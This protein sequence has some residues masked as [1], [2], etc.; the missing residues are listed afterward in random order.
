[1]CCRKATEG[2]NPSLSAIFDHHALGQRGSLNATYR[3][4]AEIGQF[5]AAL[6][7]AKRAFTLAAPDSHMRR[8]LPLLAHAFPAL[9]TSL[10][11]AAAEA[12]SPP[13]A[14]QPKPNILWV[15][16]EDNTYNFVGAYGDPLAR[17]PN[18]DLLAAQGIVFDL[19]HSS[20]PVCAPSRHT[21]I[22]G[23]Y[24]TTHGAQHMRSQRPLPPGV[25][26]FPE[27]LRAAGYY[28]TNNTKTDYN[29][30]TPFDHVWNE[31]GRN[32][33][34]RHRAP[35]QP[36]F[37]V[38]NFEHSHES[39]QHKREPLIT[40]PA[41]V[42]L[43]AYLPDTPT[44][45]AD[46]AQYYD[47]VSRAD[48]AI[49][50]VLK[51]LAEDGLADDTIVLYYSDNGGTLPRSK[52]FLWDNGTHVAMIA[53]FPEK[54]RALAPAAPGTHSREL[55]NFV[56]LAPTVLSLAGLPRP[57]YFQGRAIAGAT[58][59]PAPPFT[60][61]FRGRMDESYDLSRAVNDGRYRYVR[62][63]LP[64]LPAG[65]HVTYLWQQASMREWDELYRAGKL[66][67][68]QSAFFEP[69]PPE[70][71][72][73]CDADPENVKNLA[74]EPAH[75]STLLKF[76]AALRGHLLRTRDTGFLPEPMMLAQANGASPTVVS[77][78]LE[79][80][81]LERL[82]DFIDAAQ[83]GQATGQQIVAATHHPLAVYRYWAVTAT[84]AA[85]TPPNF[86]ELLYDSDASVRLAAAEAVLRRGPSEAAWKV[87][88]DSLGA[89]RSRELRLTALNA[90]PYLPS[91]PEMLRPLIAACGDTED[92]YLK[93]TAEFLLA[94]SGAKSAVP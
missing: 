19:A 18:L 84:L 78:V 42:K 89:S 74:A 55:V 46:L 76:R 69:R 75:K 28:C 4:G 1:M 41:K 87:I 64:H 70:E 6:R 51:Q 67:R 36:F 8:L 11:L 93:R 80:Y 73:D 17:T 21:I 63:Y 32:A 22:T 40:D 16:S 12:S 94:P 86:S 61:T 44:S 34:W 90:L 23:V 24:A 49:G 31:N 92:E 29:T 37:A 30:S 26:F 20:A 85:K 43:P 77:D 35:G 9:A 2:S 81:P 72:Y 33:H 62:N 79:R 66:N 25:K 50:V 60:F 45:R 88:A 83:F 10:A 48:A 68:T 58:R 14:S 7:R 65:Q 91:R 39:K 53:H 82:L 38:F 54:F 57:A 52:R 71:L 47:N 15:V 59:Q 27:F 5:D 56:D 13:A 3:Q